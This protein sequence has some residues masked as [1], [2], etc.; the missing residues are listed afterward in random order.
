M[1]LDHLHHWQ[2]YAAAESL[3]DFA[4][5]GVCSVLS[6]GRCGTSPFLQLTFLLISHPDHSHVLGYVYGYVYGY[7]DDDIDPAFMDTRRGGCTWCAPTAIP[8]LDDTVSCHGRGRSISRAES[9]FT[10]EG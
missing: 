4:V 6:S 3:K 10:A 9:R 2:S 7:D 5:N 8:L 1:R